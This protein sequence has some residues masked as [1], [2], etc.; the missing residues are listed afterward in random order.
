MR[1][2]FDDDDEFDAIVRLRS[3]PPT[4]TRLRSNTP[5]ATAPHSECRLVVVR[6]CSAALPRATTLHEVGTH[7]H[8][9]PQPAA[10]FDADDYD[11][12]DSIA[13]ARLRAIPSTVPLCEHRHAAPAASDATPAPVECRL[14]AAG[15][16]AAP[17]CAPAGTDGWTRPESDRERQVVMWL[18]ERTTSFS[19]SN[20]PRD[21][22][23]QEPEPS[24]ARA[25]STA[26]AAPRGRPFRLF[27]KTDAFSRLELENNS[28]VR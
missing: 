20:S 15:S 6:Q 7:L 3:E 25:A 18:H 22:E 14:V 24:G 8:S 9:R 27:C 5:T 23:A 13:D 19:G 21:S 16:H 10:A 4:A 26:K 11:E 12:F 1:A 17:A 28:E 2:A